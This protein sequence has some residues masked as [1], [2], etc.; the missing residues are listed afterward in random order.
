MG[1]QTQLCGVISPETGGPQT[2]QQEM[3]MR[4]A[5][6]SSKYVGIIILLSY[7]YL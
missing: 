4:H 2:F 1:A 3:L 5:K 7:N 6:P